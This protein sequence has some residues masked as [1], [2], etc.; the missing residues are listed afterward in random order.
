MSFGGLVEAVLRRHGGLSW[1][2]WGPLGG[3]FW[4]SWGPHG[5]SWGP[6]GGLL[7]ALWASWGLLGAEGSTCP[8][9]SPFWALSWS[10]L[11]GSGAILDSSWAVLGPSWAV[12]GPSWG[13][14]GPSWG[15]LGGLL[16]RLGAPGGQKRQNPPNLQK[17]MGSHDVCLLG[18][19]WEASWRHPGASW[20]LLRPSGGN[21]GRLGA[22]S[23]SSSDDASRHPCRP[24]KNSS[25][26]LLG[27]R[28][29]QR[30]MSEHVLRARPLSD[31]NVPPWAA[32][33][34]SRQKKHR[35]G[36]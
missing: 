29:A 30:G 35:P 20:R 32:A 28:T 16:D 3:L 22:K 34:R 6:L 18:P 14:I 27:V 11:G 5:A 24:T 33:A 21:L 10:R 26:N 31:T 8:F 25:W 12:L 15:D 1:A 2:S 19:S 9:R 17:P 4:A 13:P 23:F 7:G 36:T